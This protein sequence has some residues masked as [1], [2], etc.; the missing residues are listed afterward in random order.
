[1]RHDAIDNRV[2]APNLLPRHI[3]T[4]GLRADRR[5]DTP[6]SSTYYKITNITAEVGGI[7]GIAMKDKKATYLPVPKADQGSGVTA[8][9]YGIDASDEVVGTVCGAARL[10]ASVGFVYLNGKSY[11]LNTLIPPKSGWQIAF[12][13]GVNDHG[14]I[15]G[16]RYYNGNAQGIS[17]KPP[18]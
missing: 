8:V 9:A 13:L 15:A 5:G 14:E 3:R 1:M 10:N 4:F 11:D 7:S 12:A 17:L 2:L 6:Y 18:K 16:L